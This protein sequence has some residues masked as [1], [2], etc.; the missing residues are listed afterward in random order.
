MAMI[1]SVIELPCASPGTFITNERAIF[2][3]DAYMLEINFARAELASR[4]QGLDAV[5]LRLDSEEVDL[6]A[7]LSLEY[8]ADF[9]EV[10]SDLTG[11]QAAL[12]AG[13]MSTAKILQMTLL[14]YL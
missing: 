9:V 3:L 5:Q 12:Q 10:V 4:Q 13:L 2:M 7:T 11:R 1:A 8:D 6:R 14:D